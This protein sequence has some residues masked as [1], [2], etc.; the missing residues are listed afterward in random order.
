MFD[1]F[2]LNHVHPMLVH[3]PIVLIMI[4]FL[5]QLLSLIF[6]DKGCF[7]D[8]AKW[9]IYLG[10][11]AAVAGYISGEYFT[12]ELTGEAGEL[13]EN[14][15]LFAKI[16]MWLM[17]GASALSLYLSYAKNPESKLNWI[18]FFLTLA[19]AVSVGIA[20]FLGGSLV[21]NFMIGL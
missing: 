10:T 4:G 9:L 17:V 1:L 12:K 7:K 20:G 21:Y 5:A 11:I 16:A 18:V 13:K 8:V 14:H 6:K 19:A 3:F 2:N 15:E